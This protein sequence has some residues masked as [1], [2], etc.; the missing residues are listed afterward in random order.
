M[1][2]L[3]RADTSTEITR[4]VFCTT[5]VPSAAEVLHKE[6]LLGTTTV[7]GRDVA[8]TINVSPS[9]YLFC[10]VGPNLAVWTFF[11][12]TNETLEPLV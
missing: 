6:A 2:L 7:S 8:Q 1:G 12:L 9:F 5:E 10:S 3:E 11:L 4:A